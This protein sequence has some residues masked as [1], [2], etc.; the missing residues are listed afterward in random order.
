MEM[1]KEIFYHR[2]NDIL[3]GGKVSEISNSSRKLYLTRINREGLYEMYNYSK[4]ERLYEFF[5]F[6]PQKTIDDTKEYLEKLLHRESEEILDRKAIHWFVR[7]LTDNRLVGTFCL[8]NIDYNRKSAEWGYAVDPDLWGMGYAL[9]IMSIGKQFAFM[10][11]ELNRIYGHTLITNKRAI[12]ALISAGCT[13]EGILRDYFQK[14]GQFIDAWVYSILRREYLSQCKEIHLPYKRFK[15]DPNEVV[16]IIS[17]LILEDIYDYDKDMSMYNNWDSFS[18]LNITAEL[19]K[20][21]KCS[22]TPEEIMELRTINRI[23]EIVSTKT[24]GL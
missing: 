7:R 11:L 19:Q 21:F 10:T 23:C 2:I 13:N 22:F 17:P 24:P 3:P 14:N 4:N 6:S 12:S 1:T 5:E 20:K 8:V 16:T 15:I 9:E 18:H